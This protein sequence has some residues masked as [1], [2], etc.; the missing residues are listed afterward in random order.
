MHSL[1]THD[2]RPLRST[3]P[4]PPPIVPPPPAPPPPSQRFF[5]IQEAARG[6]VG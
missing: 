6:G 4:C 5:S 2:R 3:P 1:M